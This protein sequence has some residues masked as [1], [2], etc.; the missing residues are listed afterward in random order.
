MLLISAS[1]CL[2]T[3]P[4]GGLRRES[5]EIPRP[6]SSPMRLAWL[7]RLLPRLSMSSLAVRGPVTGCVK[8]ACITNSLGPNILMS[9]FGRSHFFPTAFGANEVVAVF[10]RR[11]SCRRPLISPDRFSTTV[12]IIASLISPC[13][14]IREKKYGTTNA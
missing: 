14:S 10:D 7:S 5:I 12:A 13:L 6:F 8:C 1:W 9:C 11:K 2:D 3:D 4:Y